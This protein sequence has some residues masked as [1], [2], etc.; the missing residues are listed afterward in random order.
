MHTV[1]LHQDGAT[2][3]SG[4]KKRRVK[5]TFSQQVHSSQHQRSRKKPLI[6]LVRSYTSNV[7]L[8]RVIRARS[9]WDCYVLAEL[10][11]T[12]Q[13]HRRTSTVAPYG[14]DS[15]QGLRVSLTFTH[16]RNERISQVFSRT[17]RPF[18]SLCSHSFHISDDES[19]ATLVETA[20]PFL[21]RNPH[22]CTTRTRILP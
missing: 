16:Q 9:R 11:D 1:G 4:E 5:M 14:Q 19:C 13:V 20:A 6:L 3:E 7:S 8:Q 21:R 18:V 17:A 22:I 15:A 2:V 12:A 10:G